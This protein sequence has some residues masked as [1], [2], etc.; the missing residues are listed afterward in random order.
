[1]D[2]TNLNSIDKCTIISVDLANTEDCTAQLDYKLNNFKKDAKASIASADLCAVTELGTTYVDA[3]KFN[4]YTGTNEKATVLNLPTADEFIKANEPSV[5]W[6]KQEKWSEPKYICPKCNEGGMRKEN[7]V[8]YTSY[9]PCYKYQCDKCG[10][11]T[12]HHF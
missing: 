5:L 6:Y 2:K 7:D 12:W 3:V 8:V 11:T 10:Y 4:T 9:P 1:M